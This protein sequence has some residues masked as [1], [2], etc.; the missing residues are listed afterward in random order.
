MHTEEHELFCAAGGAERAEDSTASKSRNRFVILLAD[1]K[2]I[3]E[4]SL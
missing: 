1:L 3:R 2:P 4:L